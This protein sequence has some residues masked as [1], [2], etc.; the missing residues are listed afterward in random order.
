ML[1][2]S[3]NQKTGRELEKLALKNSISDE[4]Q[5]VGMFI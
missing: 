5:E 4:L 2:N 3:G 1:C